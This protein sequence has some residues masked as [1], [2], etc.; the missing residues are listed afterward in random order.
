MNTSCPT[1]PLCRLASCRRR[2]SSRFVCVRVLC[3]SYGDSHRLSPLAA[4][5]RRSL[6]AHA[7]VYRARSNRQARLSIRIP[8]MQIYLRIDA[9]MCVSVFDGAHAN[10]EREREK[11]LI[12][13][14]KRRT[15]HA[16]CAIH[17]TFTLPTLSGKR[18]PSKCVV[19][20]WMESAL[21]THDRIT[22]LSSL[23]RSA[24]RCQ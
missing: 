16:S 23:A 3:V 21:S 5:P 8:R 2:F 12:Y 1:I 10:R 22:Y 11:E 7:Y 15:V 24:S 14:Y 19:H 13:A 9:H 17:T 18:P 6:P 4:S 20:A